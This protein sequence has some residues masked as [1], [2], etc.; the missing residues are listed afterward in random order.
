MISTLN[1][2]WSLLVINIKYCIQNK[3]ITFPSRSH[4]CPYINKLSKQRQ[5][6]MLMITVISLIISVL[7]RFVSDRYDIYIGK[8]LE[9][10][11]HQTARPN[12]LCFRTFHA[13]YTWFWTCWPPCRPPCT[14]P[15]RPPCQPLSHRRNAKK[16]NREEKEKYGIHISSFE[17][18]KEKCRDLFSGSRREWEFL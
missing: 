8:V 14:P 16:W 9:M 15:C 2:K 13:F 18:R 5:M 4:W 17:K 3:K 6:L 12:T 11:L 7:A 10:L 1:K